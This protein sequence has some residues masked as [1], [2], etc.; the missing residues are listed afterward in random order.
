[1]N[2]FGVRLGIRLVPVAG[3]LTAALV[4]S[5]GAAPA[6]AQR[7]GSRV[8]SRSSTSVFD[9]TYAGTSSI[10][11][12]ATGGGG[13]Y[14][15]SSPPSKVTFSVVGGRIV[16]SPTLVISSSS[17]LSNTGTAQAKIPTPYGN[18]TMRFDFTR[19]AGGGVT[20]TG[21]IS[22]TI[23]V[24]SGAVEQQTKVNGELHATRVGDSSGRDVTEYERIGVKMIEAKRGTPFTPTSFCPTKVRLYDICGAFGP[25][26]YDFEFG[27]GSDLL[28]PGMH[29]DFRSG[30]LYGTPSLRYGP[31][32]YRLIICRVGY[33]GVHQ[34]SKEC[35]LTTLVVS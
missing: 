27:P 13:S 28:A 21:T 22:L 19:T 33:H 3:C 20:V 26:T 35:G 32:T 29:L 6:F 2:E 11:I 5:A 31:H 34:V 8:V 14:K 4:V 12:V 25:T 24:G 17:Q 10:T 15:K 9:G 16:A 30:T 18:G 1:M 23:T 7:S